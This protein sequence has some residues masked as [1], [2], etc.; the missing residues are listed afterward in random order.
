M[1]LIERASL[2]FRNYGIATTLKRSWLYILRAAIPP[3]YELITII[4]ASRPIAKRKCCCCGYEG[5]FSVFG[6]PLRLDARCPKCDSL[7]RHRLFYLG[8][9]SGV[10]FNSE[11]I[12]ELVIH[13]SAEPVLEKLFRQKCENYKTADLFDGADLKLDM[14]KMEIQDDSVGTVI[15]NH[16]LEHVDDTKALGEIFRILKK[17]GRLICS[18]PIVEGWDKTYENDAVHSE[19]DRALHFGQ[20]DHVRFY[21]RDFRDRVLDAG[22]RAYCE[23]TAEGR[24]VID[25]GL[26][27]GEKVFVFG[28]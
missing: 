8:F 23:V 15:A 3:A 2:S 9:N 28:K 19:A 27:R 16:I 24:Q 21:G 17:G 1:K 4:K 12:R 11:T 14:E 13:F 5:N 18:V 10:F 7:E 26:L 22:F 20:I 6:C 25:H